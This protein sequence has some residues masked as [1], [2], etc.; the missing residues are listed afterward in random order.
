MDVRNHQRIL[1]KSHPFL[2]R[3]GGSSK[4][5]EFPPE[6]SILLSADNQVI[7][8][9]RSQYPQQSHNNFS[10]RGKAYGRS[11]WIPLPRPLPSW[12]RR[13][14]LGRGQW[15]MT[16]SVVKKGLLVFSGQ[17]TIPDRP[18]KEERSCLKFEQHPLERST[19]WN[20]SPVSSLKH[21]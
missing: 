8:C 4:S 9:P 15:L 6:N 21:S 2:G 1:T 13:S 11:Q 20:P 14:V 7:E 3:K 10:L 5:H 19:G 18:H 12:R 17:D 16:V